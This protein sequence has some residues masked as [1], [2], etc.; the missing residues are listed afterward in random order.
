MQGHP[1]QPILTKEPTSPLSEQADHWPSGGAS[2]VDSL[3]WGDF[4]YDWPL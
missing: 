1:I 4:P 2:A 3:L